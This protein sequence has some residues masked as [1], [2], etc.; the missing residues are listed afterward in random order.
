MRLP[1]IAVTAMVEPEI[2]EKMVPATTATTD[3]RPGTLVIRRSTASMT[4]T[5]RPVWNSTSPIRTNSGM[6]VSE[7]LATESTQLRASCTRPTSP[8][9]QPCA[10][11]VDREKGECDRQTE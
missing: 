9:E 2:A 3:S 5:A 1:S 4:F 8:Q 11:Q 10:D 6:G 7:K